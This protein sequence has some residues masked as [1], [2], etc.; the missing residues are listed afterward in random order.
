PKQA[1]YVTDKMCSEWAV[2][3]FSVEVARELIKLSNNQPQDIA[4]QM[5]TMSKLF[6]MSNYFYESW[7]NTKISHKEKR[8][9]YEQS[10][11]FF[12]NVW[13]QNKKKFFLNAFTMEALI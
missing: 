6:L 11:D 2:K 12:V 10:M 7:N 5:K 13:L 1:L 8:Q 4:N 3:V 9:L